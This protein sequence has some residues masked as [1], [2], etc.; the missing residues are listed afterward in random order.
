M[1]SAKRKSPGFWLKRVFYEG[2]KGKKSRELF[3]FLAAKKTAGR[4][5]K[6]GRDPRFLDDIERFGSPS[7]S[8][9]GKGGRL[10]MKGSPS[11]RGERKKRRGKNIYIKRK[12]AVFSM[13][14][15]AGIPLLSFTEKKEKRECFFANREERG[16]ITP[17]KYVEGRREKKSGRRWICIGER[18]GRKRGSRRNAAFLRRPEVVIKAGGRMPSLLLDRNGKKEERRGGLYL[19][20]R[21]CGRKKIDRISNGLIREK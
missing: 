8:P 3:S 2:K 13:D 20:R 17:T 19:S 18:G 5:L 7:I 11:L 16:R 12:E 21:G 1:R 9:E 6:G 4:S 14:G 15:R 10:A